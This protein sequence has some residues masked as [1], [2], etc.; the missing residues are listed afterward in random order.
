MLE[1]RPY[2]TTEWGAAYHGNALELLKEIDDEQI[3]LVFTSPPFALT[4]QKNY[5]HPPD[6]VNASKYIEWFTPFAQEIHRVLKKNGSLVLNIGSAW[7]PNMPTKSLY[8]FELLL[9]LCK[10][11]KFSLAQDFYWYNTAKFPSPAEWTNIRRVRVKDA[12]DPIWWLSKDPQGKTTA[13]NTR[14]LVKYSESMKTLLKTKKYDAGHR[15][16]GYDVSPTSFLKKHR[17]AISPNLLQFA[18]TAS[19]GPYMSNCKKYH[20]E[21]NPARFPPALADFFIRFLTSKEDQVILDPFSGSNTT[22]YV[23]QKLNRRWVAFE[24]SEEYIKGSQ[25]RFYTPEELGFAV[26][27]E[28]IETKKTNANAAIDDFIA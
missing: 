19:N 15:P 28:D 23:A 8:H 14:V 11:Q 16:S 3:D 21:V 7:N 25:F 4:R 12:V 17:G 13:R 24:I 9:D 10:N 6:F 27:P 18:N 26:P 5:K 2:Y 22:G 1:R 20:I